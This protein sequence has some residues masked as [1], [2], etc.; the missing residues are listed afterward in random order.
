MGE[1][2]EA[3]RDKLGVLC[4]EHDISG[5]MFYPPKS[6]DFVTHAYQDI[7]VI[8]SNNGNSSTRLILELRAMKIKK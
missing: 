8:C 3:L 6:V 5:L 1:Q 7:S 2:I 4:K